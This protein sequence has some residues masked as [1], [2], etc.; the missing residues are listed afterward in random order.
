[1]KKVIILFTLVFLV[2]GCRVK[3]DLTINE[4]L[5][6]NEETKMT[7]TSEFFDNYYKTTKKNVLKSMIEIYQDILIDNNYQYNLQ[8]D[9]IPYVLVTRKYNSVNDYVSNSILFNGY[10]D[11]VKYSEKGNIK[12]IETIGFYD[13]E[14][15]NPDRFNV[16]ELEIAIHCPFNVVRHNAIRVDEM[17]NT[18]YYELSEEN[19]KIII[20]YDIN[21]K[22]NPNAS[23]IKIIFISILV[24]ACLCLVLLFLNK[25][26][27]KNSSETVV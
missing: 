27:N 6:V 17:T 7:G 10:F 26:N 8:D 15:D 25:K 1:M 20:E 3:Y 16:K 24:I 5:T 22:F 12:R 19:D 18:Y 13:N 9:T 23:L 14:P 21:S 11:E 2:T 4:D